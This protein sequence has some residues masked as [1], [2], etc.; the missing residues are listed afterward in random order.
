LNSKLYQLLQSTVPTDPL[1]RIVVVFLPILYKRCSQS[2]G[3]C[4]QSLTKYTHSLTDDL[5]RDK[6]RIFSPKSYNNIME[7]YIFFSTY[8]IIFISQMFLTNVFWLIWLN[9]ICGNIWIIIMYSVFFL[10]LNVIQVYHLLHL[11]HVFLYRV[12][13][14]FFAQ[15]QAAL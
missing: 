15:L 13:S 5:V 2:G 3:S 14:H 1:A 8:S 7:F 11:L 12:V 10:F 4:D 6:K 9:A